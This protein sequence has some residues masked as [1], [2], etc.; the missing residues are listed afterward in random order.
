MSC[1]T[2]ILLNLTYN[3]QIYGCSESNLS[4]FVSAYRNSLLIIVEF[5][6]LKL[7][8]SWDQRHTLKC[9]VTD[10]AS[11]HSL[12]ELLEPIKGSYTGRTHTRTRHCI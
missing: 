9:F 12:Y 10:K 7:K 1:M 4:K 11:R 3:K 8:Y 2:N 6:T 5:Y